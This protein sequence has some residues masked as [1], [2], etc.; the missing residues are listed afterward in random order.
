MKGQ[1]SL[2]ICSSSA[3]FFMICSSIY[4]YNLFFSK[5]TLEYRDSRRIRTKLVTYLSLSQSDRCSVL[6]AVHA[7]VV[8]DAY[9]ASRGNRSEFS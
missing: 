2:V 7:D 6:L 4:R 9:T 1:H 8:T 5:Y 3:Y